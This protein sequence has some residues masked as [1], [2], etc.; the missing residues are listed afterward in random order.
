[1]AKKKQMKK[2][3]KETIAMK[4]TEINPSYE[5]WKTYFLLSSKKPDNVLFDEG[6]INE[7]DSTTTFRQG[8]TINA[9]E[10]EYLNFIR[11]LKQQRKGKKER[12]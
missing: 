5:E 7:K 4:I 2:A 9:T 6:Y 12:K 10:K 1:M 11:W 8:F 3:E